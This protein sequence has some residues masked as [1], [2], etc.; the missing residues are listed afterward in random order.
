[1]D[2]E[3]KILGICRGH[4]DEMVGIVSKPGCTPSLPA[5]THFHFGKVV[6]CSQEDLIVDALIVWQMAEG[7]ML[8]TWITYVTR[9]RK[10]ES[11]GMTHKIS[12]KRNCQGG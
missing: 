1:M 11:H 2:D 3:G 8:A 10:S 5:E 12:V 4:E 9:G 7:Q 6:E